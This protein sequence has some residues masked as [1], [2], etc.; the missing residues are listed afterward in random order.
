MR[1]RIGPVT[2]LIALMCT[3][4][5]G[6]VRAQITVNWFSAN[7]GLSNVL[8]SD[9]LSGSP[10]ATLI[11]VPTAVK[12][13]SLYV[14][15]TTADANTADYYDIGVGSCPGNDCSQPN[16]PIE[17][18]CDW[19][20]SSSG[21]NLTSASIQSH[22]CSQSTPITIQ[23]GVYVLLG[24]GNATVAKC[25]GQGG[26]TGIVPWSTTVQGSA[27]NGSLQNVTTG[28]F[29]TSAT[30]GARIAGDSCSI[31]LH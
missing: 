10:T 15:I 31:S 25:S 22:P 5:A 14:K 29:K 8:V 30:A 23:P 6:V 26:S 18:I 13:S 7:Q 1:L 24:A 17:I 3:A 27:V 2:A 4:T 19:G 21:I 20:D 9:S 28:S 16:V 11:Y 12:F